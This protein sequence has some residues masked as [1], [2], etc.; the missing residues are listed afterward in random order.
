MTDSSAALQQAGE[1]SQSASKPEPCPQGRTDYEACFA[2]FR[3][4]PVK[5]CGRSEAAPVPCCGDAGCTCC[6]ATGEHEHVAPRAWRLT[7]SAQ[8]TSGPWSRGIINQTLGEPVLDELR[9]N[10]IGPGALDDTSRWRE[11]KIHRVV[12]RHAFTDHDCQ[13]TGCLSMMLSESRELRDIVLEAYE[14]GRRDQ[15]GEPWKPG[16]YPDA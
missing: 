15:R 2:P 5:G 11:H 6:Q 14:R 3:Y 12:W 16:E 10:P 8:A 4:C 13:S 7:E 9:D 1:P